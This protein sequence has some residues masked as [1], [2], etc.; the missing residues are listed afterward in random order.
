MV[1]SVV[2]SLA[3][4]AL[5]SAQSIADLQA[6]IQALLA[7]IKLL[8]QQIA[9]QGASCHDFN[10][11]LRIGSQGDEVRALQSFLEKEGFKI[12]TD[13]TSNAQYGEGTASAVTGFQEKYAGDILTPAGLQYG[14]GFT[15]N[16]TRKK[17]NGLYGC[18]NPILPSAPPGGTTPPSP[19]PTPT[20]APINPPSGTATPN[21]LGIGPESGPVGTLVTLKGTSFTKTG[22]QVSFGYGSIMNLESS[23]NL[24]TFTVPESLT[25]ACYY[26]TPRCLIAT[27]LTAPGTYSVMVTNANGT[28]N[29]VKF[30][31]TSNAERSVSLSATPL[32][33][34]APLTVSFSGVL[35][36]F[37]SC[38]NSYSWNFGDGSASVYAESCIGEISTLP[39]RTISMTHTY[40]I[41]GKYVAS[42]G[43][44]GI[45]SNSVNITATSST[46][47]TTAS[48]GIVSPNGG[49]NWPLYSNQRIYISASGVPTGATYDV[50][51]KSADNL[52]YPDYFF[53]Q[54]GNLTFIAASGAAQLAVLSAYVP[55][56]PAGT[57]K[58]YVRAVSGGQVVTDSTSKATFMI[59]TSTYTY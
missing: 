22:N 14:T 17:L 4:P 40:T 42:V 52:S 27:K 13:E 2:A 25:P 15:G 6:Q 23:G 48:L 10:A 16:G 5:S 45:N 47:P 31:V 32:S 53:L 35:N 54:N 55:S 30:T 9:Q 3:L 37:P 29:S 43:V 24:I 8:Q 36:N 49:E 18:G 51:L 28:S 59:T 46:P 33:G 56:V 21:I 7:Q 41:A 39:S 38:S 44:S 11:N 19:L 1:L 34:A 58:V 26:S 12:A 20:P 50:V 57:Y